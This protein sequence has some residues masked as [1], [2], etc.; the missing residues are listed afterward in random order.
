MDNLNYISELA[1]SHG[2]VLWTIEA[3]H[4]V[5]WLNRPA[6]DSVLKKFRREKVPDF[7]ESGQKGRQGADF[8]YSFEHLMDCVVAMKFVAEGLPFRHVV[9]LM[10]FDP[11][12]LRQH[13][14]RAFLEAESAQGAS[15]E[16]SAKDGRKITIGGLYLDFHAIISKNGVL[17][18]P[19]PRLLDPWSALNR[20]MG[21]YAGLHPT[22]MVRLS[23]LATEAVRIA[24]EAPVTKRGRKS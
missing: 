11:E 4:I 5:D 22:G 6:L 10:R 17:S 2:Q 8:A 15:L 14:R 13:Y 3:M 7:S 12:K 20:Y 16:V 19:G 24:R 18:T 9:G 23:Q 21:F 1:L